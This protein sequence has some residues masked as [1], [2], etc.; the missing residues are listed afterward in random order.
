MR[1]CVRACARVCACLV[2]LTFQL[3]QHSFAQVGF[4]NDPSSSGKT[5]ADD[6]ENMS[7]AMLRCVIKV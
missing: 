3:W 4:D 5:T 6:V 1:A 2:S 7:Q